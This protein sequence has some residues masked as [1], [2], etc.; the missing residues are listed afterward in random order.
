M[1]ARRPLAALLPLALAATAGCTDQDPVQPQPPEPS[2]NAAASAPW[3]P[4]YRDVG[5]QFG[6]SYGC[7]SF[8][9]P[10]DHD[11]PDGP[12][13]SLAVVRLP[14]TDPAR[15]IGSLLVNPG[16][17]GGSG[18]DFVLF[19]GPA[20]GFVWGPEVRARFDIVGF[21]PRGI[22][23]STAIRCFG[24]ERQAAE[25]FAP[26]AFPLTPEEEALF[27]AGDGLLADQCDRRGTKIGDHMSTASVA[28][29]MDLLR[30][31]LGDERLTYAGFSYGSYLGVTYANLFPDRVRAIL[32]DG[33]LD[34]VAWAN[35]EGAIP[36]STRLRSDQGAQTTLERFFTLCDAAS[37]GNCAL[38][39]DSESR[40]ANLAATLLAGPV[41]IVDPETGE[42]SFI[43][44]QDVIGFMLGTLYDPLSYAD[45]AEVLALLEVL[46]PPAAIGAA[47][48]RLQQANGLINKRGFPNYV[49]AAEGFVAVACEDTSNP[50][51]YGVWSA[52]GAAADAAFGYF[53]RI[54]TWASSPCAQ[55][56]LSDPGRYTG[57]FSA[58]TANPVLVI[59][60]LYDP[61]TRYEGA[62]TVRGL[63]PNSALVTLDMPGHT[64]LGLSG[65][66]GFVSGRYLLDP[67]TAPSADGLVCPAEFNPFDLAAAGDAAESA[68]MEVRARMLRQIAFRPLR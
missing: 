16:G 26:V 21:D 51:S 19:F 11:R 67:S 56:P 18:V 10:L 54:W 29:D 14:A 53:G 24:N 5:A 36:F 7:R 61:A 64:S 2:F 39:P 3:S 59:G 8:N 57:P 37:S 33:V 41:P 15:K 35:V 20:A 32:I 4:C 49:N 38:A 55:W 9:V 52:E 22:G 45:A 42:A 12:A 25:V 58:A 48:A 1:S 31:W 28:R 60:N 40:F 47:Y 63:L 68:G 46:A 50:A 13:V 30:S 43:S 27:E 17:P 66:A 34:P 6:V 62:A 23:R 44:Y 65:C